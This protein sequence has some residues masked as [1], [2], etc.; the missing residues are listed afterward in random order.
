[1][2]EMLRRDIAVIR[3]KL[4]KGTLGKAAV[5][6]MLMMVVDA[7]VVPSFGND[8]RLLESKSERRDVVSYMSGVLGMYRTGLGPHEELKLAKVI[9]A[10]AIRHE[11]DPLFVLALIKTEST[12]YN[13]SKSFAGALG[14]MQIRLETGEELAGQLKLQWNGEETLLDPYLNVRMGVHYLSSLNKRYNDRDFSLA[15]YNVGPGRL[16]SGLRQNQD[17]G[18]RYVNK[19][20]GNYKD[21]KDMAG[22]YSYDG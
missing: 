1:M 10:E 2:L 8:W 13:W 6:L 16:D 18:R 3:L 17:P 7:C 9:L 12:Y 21:L 5:A 19:V 22:V 20:L 15:A 4:N 11:M 14:L